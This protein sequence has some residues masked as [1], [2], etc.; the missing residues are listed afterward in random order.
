MNQPEDEN[1]LSKDSLCMY[2]DLDNLQTNAA[3]GASIPPQDHNHNA[4]PVHSKEQIVLSDLP[5]LNADQMGAGQSLFAPVGNSRNQHI[6]QLL[7]L[8]TYMYNLHH[9]HS[10]NDHG[11]Q[12]LSSNTFPTEFNSFSSP[13]SNNASPI[14]RSSHGPQ[15]IFDM[16][17]RNGHS[18]QTARLAFLSHMNHH[19]LAVA[20]T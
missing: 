10:A 17:N 15:K 3:P 2:M 18:Q 19:R 6:Q 20:L 9:V 7:Q 11:I 8:S 12:L 4:A 5:T 14:G 16:E 13:A 1:M